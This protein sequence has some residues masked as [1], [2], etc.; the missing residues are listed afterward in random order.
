MA[1]WLSFYFLWVSLASAICSVLLLGWGGWRAIERKKSLAD[2][3]KERSRLEQKKLLAQKRQAELSERCEALGLPSSAID[4]V[5]VQKLVV[6]H[7]ELLERYW[8]QGDIQ[9]TDSG[10]NCDES[11]CT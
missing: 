10:V 11:E 8:K 7:H 3:Q 9:V 4:L 1:W 2:C 6:T 5:R